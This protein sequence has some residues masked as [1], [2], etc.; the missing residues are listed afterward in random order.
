MMLR[1][2]RL[3]LVLAILNSS[4]FAQKDSTIL[5]ER[6][7]PS[8]SN[9]FD[10][11]LMIV[12]FK[13]ILY[14]S[15]IDEDVADA[16][17]MNQAD[18]RF[19]FKEELM[20]SMV[21][22]ARKERNHWGIL[23]L[24]ETYAEMKGDMECLMAETSYKYTSAEDLKRPQ[25]TKK[26][27]KNPYGGQLVSDKKY[28]SKKPPKQKS[29]KFLKASVKNQDM[30][31]YLSLR[32]NVNYFLFINELDLLNVPSGGRGNALND[33]KRVARVHFT[34]MD[35]YGRETYSGTEKVRFS[36][37]MNTP[38][39]IG[40]ACFTKLSSIVVSSLPDLKRHK[41]EVRAQQL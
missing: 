10:I 18:I 7:A 24:D 34:V 28:N 17:E 6:L 30:L 8:V 16:T 36:S 22:A 12:P 14:N 23:H 19:E 32:Y 25:R 20:F 38:N 41:S 21:R 40:T 13:D 2:T 39:R 15:N 33:A 31:D 9:I 3:I 37:Q 26:P 29:E 35:K 1:L 5:I 27:A 4:L 11:G